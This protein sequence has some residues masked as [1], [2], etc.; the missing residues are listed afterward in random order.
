MN[1]AIKD[2]KYSQRRA[3]ALVGM[4]PRV[5]RYASSRPDDAELRQR[6]RELSSERRRFGYRRLHLLLKREGIEVN[7]KR[8][9]R[10]YRAL[11]LNLRIKPRKR[12]KRDK[13]D[14]LAVPD[15]PNMTWSMDFMADRLGDGRQ[16]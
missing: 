15:A 9:Y 16:F 13:P 4:A 3:C 5:Y 6:L 2:K 11:E 10:I 7:W 12:L 8:V 14:A 1:W